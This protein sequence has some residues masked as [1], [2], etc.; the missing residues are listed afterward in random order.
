MLNELNAKMIEAEVLTKMQEGAA[1]NSP[2]SEL[3]EKW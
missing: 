2:E 1:G 3:A